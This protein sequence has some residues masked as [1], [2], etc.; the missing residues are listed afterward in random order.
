[1]TLDEMAALRPDVIVLP[2][3]PYAFSAADLADFAPF[4]EVPA[5]RQGRIHLIDGKLLSWYS[6][7]LGRSLSTLR[8]V[9]L[10]GDARADMAGGR[11]HGR[12]RS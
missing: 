3:E 10:P 12:T 9:L 7:R 8:H 2:D 1:V 6:P 11:A 5:V 4:T